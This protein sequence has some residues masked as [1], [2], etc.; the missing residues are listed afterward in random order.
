MFQ[1][2]FLLL[3]TESD[4]QPCIS[5]DTKYWVDTS[6][7]ETASY[8]FPLTF[9]CKILPN[10]DILLLLSTVRFSLSL[11]KIVI[12]V[13]AQQNFLSTGLEQQRKTDFRR[14]AVLADTDTSIFGCI[15]SIFQY[16]YRCLNNSNWCNNTVCPAE[17]SSLFNN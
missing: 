16:W 1:Y 2:H 8:T 9:Q 3:N 10:A 17:G 12:A 11:L 13:A 4:T 5:P 7:Y 15:G 14:T 6:T